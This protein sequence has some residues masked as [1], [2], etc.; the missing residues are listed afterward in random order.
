MFNRKLVVWAAS[1]AIL[2]GCS[3]PAPGDTRMPISTLSKSLAPGMTE[4]QVRAMREPDSISMIG[5]KIYIY[6]RDLRVRFQEVTPGVW[7]VNGWS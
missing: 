1:I 4:A 7:L 3:A 5:S 6:G 2:A